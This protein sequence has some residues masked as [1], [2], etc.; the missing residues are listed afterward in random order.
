MRKKGLKKYLIDCGWNKDMAEEVC[1]YYN[2]YGLS[3]AL[4][5]AKTN[6]LDEDHMDELKE[7]IMMW[8]YGKKEFN[9]NKKNDQID[10]SSMLEIEW[11][12]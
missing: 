5:I 10:L 4:M 2:S 8:I 12:I 3:Y 1:R 6:F 7:N 11:Q 9:L